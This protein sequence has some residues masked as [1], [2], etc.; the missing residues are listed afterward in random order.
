MAIVGLLIANYQNLITIRQIDVSISIIS[1]LI[2]LLFVFVTYLTVRQNEKTILQLEKDHYKPLARQI[3]KDTLPH[4]KFVLKQNIE[5]LDSNKVKY[6]LTLDNRVKFDL[7]IPIEN[8]F[9]R[10]EMNYDIPANFNKDE[11]PGKGSVSYQLLENNYPGYTRE[12]EQYEENIES[13][14]QNAN[15]LYENISATIDSWFDENEVTI[16][17]VIRSENIEDIE[18]KDRYRTQNL[19]KTKLNE[20]FTAIVVTE[21]LDMDSEDSFKDRIWTLYGANKEDILE[22]VEQENEEL[23]EEFQNELEEFEGKTRDLFTRTHKIEKE[24]IRIYGID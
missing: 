10:E 18:L 5:N 14:D 24:L 20:D 17:A 9:D 2:T 15:R 21:V 1:S 6:R 3:L 23:I 22:K 11:L 7:G 8:I 12:I 13:L 16:P 19:T 4:I